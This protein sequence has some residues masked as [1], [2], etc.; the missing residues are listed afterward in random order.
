MVLRM[1]HGYQGHSINSLMNGLGVSNGVFKRLRSEAKCIWVACECICTCGGTGIRSG[2]SGMT[3]EHLNINLEMSRTIQMV[4]SSRCLE[5]GLSFNYKSKSHQRKEL[6]SSE[7]MRL[8]D[9]EAAL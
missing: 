5:I 8:L 2:Q 4:T 6:A 7:S 9:G 1:V 3:S